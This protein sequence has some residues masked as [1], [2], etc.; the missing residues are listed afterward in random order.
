MLQQ[1]QLSI[2]ALRKDRSAEGFHDLLDRHSL[3]GELILGRAAEQRSVNM[4]RAVRSDSHRPDESKCPHA[5]WLQI[6]VPI[7]LSIHG[8][9][10][11]LC[12]RG[13]A[14]CW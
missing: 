2:S 5:H 13:R 7:R 6:G 10:R 8:D 14:T 11:T 12:V 9:A 1:L 4:S 3:A